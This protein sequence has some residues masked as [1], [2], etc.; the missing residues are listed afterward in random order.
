M[1]E[2]L[3]KD[4][5]L[6]EIVDTINK[7]NC[8]L[9]LG[10]DA[11]VETVNGKSQAVTESLAQELSIE[12]NE[13]NG[14]RVNDTSDLLEVARAYIDR[15]K[16]KKP[17]ILK[18][19]EFYKKRETRTSDLHMNL[20]ALPFYFSVIST[21]DKMFIKALEENGKT[22][23]I[24]SYD[25]IGDPK[26]IKEIG[27]IEK[28]LLFY[29]YGRLEEPYSLVLSEYDLLD[30]LVKV[31]SDDPPIPERIS[32]ELHSY[33]KSILFLGFGFKHWYLRILLH[34]LLKNDKEKNSYAIEQIS[35]REDDFCKSIIFFKQNK[36]KI[37]IFQD[38]LDDFVKRLRQK[39]EK[40]YGHPK[41]IK[42]FISYASENIGI[43]ILLSKLLKGKN[44]DPQYDK[45][46]LW[47]GDHWEEKLKKAIEETDYVLILQTKALE[48]RANGYVLKEIKFAL[49]RDSEESRKGKIFLIP[50]K[51]EKCSIRKEL[52]HIH[53]I[54]V[55]NDEDYNKILGFIKADQE[56]RKE[57]TND[58]K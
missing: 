15:K 31:I 26:Q 6:D 16:E 53:S 39:Y 11:S 4:E 52:K 20:A 37:C 57:I 30:F 51:V 27:T 19:A 5:Y 47:S 50:V 49:R 43:A 12:I 40:K 23:I 33:K 34:V 3:W 17:L 18:V 58:T 28:P 22:P 8:I 56:R 25:F 42:I 14:L 7:N 46:L 2:L 10:P 54:D 29:L 1:S 9:L 38:K 48:E 24:E 45:K 44:L 32:R 35:R 13:S 36:C 55:K 21:P 41:K